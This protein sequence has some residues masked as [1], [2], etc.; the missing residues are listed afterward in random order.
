M[1]Q[2]KTLQIY[3]AIEQVLWDCQP[4]KME[5]DPDY[6]YKYCLINFFC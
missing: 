2:T 5:L 4:M 1:G 6:L 3:L